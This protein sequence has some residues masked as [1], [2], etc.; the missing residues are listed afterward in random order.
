MVEMQSALAGLRVRDAMMTR[1]RTLRA[2][3]TLA[4][5]VDE[6]LAGS[7]QDFPVLENDKLIGILRRN[8]LV[9]ALSEGRSDDAVTVGMSRD[10]ET[11]DETASLKSVVESMHAQQYATM[12]VMSG[13][14]IIG[15]LTLENISEIIMVNAA[16]DH[17]GTAHSQPAK[18]RTKPQL[19]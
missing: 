6:L 2:H 3:D 11:V 12:P 15:L 10:W 9:K 19:L 17:Q 4:K 13:G 5:A 16:M 7:Q 18:L 14:R 8:D 1:F